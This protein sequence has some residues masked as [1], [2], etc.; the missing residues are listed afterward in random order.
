MSFEDNVLMYQ[1]HKNNTMNRKIT[2]IILATQ[3]QHNCC[4]GVP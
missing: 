2:N 4:G 3:G 1:S